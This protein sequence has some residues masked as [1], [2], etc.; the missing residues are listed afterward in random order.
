MISVIKHFKNY[1]HENNIS[2]KDHK[3]SYIVCNYFARYNRYDVPAKKDVK[4]SC[5]AYNN[6]NKM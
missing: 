3:V 4:S 1:L 2:S 6:H 5:V